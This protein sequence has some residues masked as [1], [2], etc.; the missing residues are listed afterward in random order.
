MNSVPGV[1]GMIKNQYW[2]WQKIIIS[3]TYQSKRYTDTNNNERLHNL[4]AFK[5]N[6]PAT[7]QTKVEWDTYN[8]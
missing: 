3:F 6:N 8:N 1:Y 7:L 4:N 2:D 5:R